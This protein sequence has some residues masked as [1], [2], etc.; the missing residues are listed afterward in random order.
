MKISALKHLLSICAPLLLLGACSSTPQSNYYLLSAKATTA[1][2]PCHYSIGVGP[3]VVAEYLNRP[4]I[5]VTGEPG[6]LQIEQ[7]Q[8]WGEPIRN[9]VERV[10]V[11]NLAILT[12]STQ[13]VVYP[14]RQDQSP[15]Y[16]VRINI[17]SMNRE[18]NSALIKVQWQLSDSQSGNTISTHLESYKAPVN[19]DGY[20]NL[21]E[22]FSDALL[23]LSVQI[24][25][26]IAD[27]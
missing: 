2:A 20:R 26:E 24:S 19:G 22:G 5:T 13:L 9:S 18:A 3:V 27:Q 8:R 25:A 1:S 4:Q 11:E 7:F 15:R 17:L 14:W 10:L 23:Q 12:D 6:Q 16:R 21:V